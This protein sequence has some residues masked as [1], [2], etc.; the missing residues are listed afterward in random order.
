MSAALPSGS[1]RPF[2]E[3]SMTIIEPASS[4]ANDAI[5]ENI[6]RELEEEIAFGRLLPGQKLPEEDLSSRFGVSR[7]HIREAL[8][9]LAATGIVVKERN[10]GVYVRSFSPEEVHQIYEVREI[11]QRQ[12]VLRIPLPAPEESIAALKAVHD[13]YEKAVASGDLRSIRKWNDLFHQEFFR[14]CGNDVLWRLVV[15]Y[16]ELSYAIRANSFSPEHQAVAR[17]EHLVMI[18]LLRTR[19]AWALS[20]LCIDHMEYSKQQYLSMLQQQEPGARAGNVRI[21]ASMA[22]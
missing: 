21:A 8:A 16:M 13:D 19:D 7:H 14:L 11:L 6:S 18:S 12:A 20:Q 22:V 2:A 1:S 9:R 5:A 4:A 10:R 17:Q 15:H 3:P